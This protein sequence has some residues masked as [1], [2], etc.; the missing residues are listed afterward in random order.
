MAVVRTMHWQGYAWLPVDKFR[1]TFQHVRNFKPILFARL[2][3][4]HLLLE[5]Q[6]WYDSFKRI[7]HH[8][9][10]AVALL[11]NSV[12]NRS[13]FYNLLMRFESKIFLH[14]TVVILRNVEPYSKEKVQLNSDW[15]YIVVN[16]KLINCFTRMRNYWYLNLFLNSIVSPL[17]EQQLY[18][19]IYLIK[20]SIVC[21]VSCVF[22]RP[23]GNVLRLQPGV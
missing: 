16:Y 15:N 19:I 23:N 2:A 11:K 14:V 8:F 20:N 5:W 7:F 9:R 1:I 17:F 12:K 13:V 10:C 4:E 3:Y 22:H 21:T 6:T 18:H